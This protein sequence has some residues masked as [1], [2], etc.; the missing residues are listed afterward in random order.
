MNR[1]KTISQ[2]AQEAIDVQNA[3]NLRGVLRSWWEALCQDCVG[4]GSPEELNLNAPYLSK[5]T[6]LLC[7][8][9][10]GIGGVHVRM[11]GLK[12]IQDPIGFSS[13]YDW[14]KKASEVSK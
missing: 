1:G 10:D 5:V 12:V 9:A 2:L 7:A 6:S 4:H 13:A 11:N 14:A 3:S 8:S